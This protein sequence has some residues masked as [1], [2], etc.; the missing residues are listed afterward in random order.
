MNLKQHLRKGFTLIEL[1]V[2][3][4][5]IAILAGLLLPALSKA[6]IKAQG[7]ASMSNLKQLQTCYQMYLGDNRDFLVP[8]E[9]IS[10]ASLP[11]AWVVGNPKNDFDLTCT[12]IRN[13]YLFQY[14]TSIK[15]YKCPTDNSLTTAIPGNPGQPRNRSY[16]IDYLLGGNVAGN[17][18]FI[19]KA[20]QIVNPGPAEKS[21]F[22]DEDSRSIDN[23]AFGINP[24]PSLVWQN[25]PAAHHNHSSVLSFADGHA[26]THH[27][28]LDGVLDVGHP[29]D[30]P[31]GVAINAPE[32]APYTDLRW[33]QTTSFP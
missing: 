6:K 22:W 19:S 16:A 20:S 17:T 14:N 1:L 4:A 7:I 32:P 18:R 26:I 9:A 33:T 23:G 21:V 24:S 28:L 8:N 2:V 12:N 3:I 11:T 25:L 30:A 27:W 15:I 10:T 13:G 31:S 5:I 29:A